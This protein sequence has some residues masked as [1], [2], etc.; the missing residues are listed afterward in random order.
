[1]CNTLDSTQNCG[2]ELNVNTASC[3]QRSKG[4][5]VSTAGQIRRALPKT[6]DSDAIAA[7]WVQNNLRVCVRERKSSSL[8]YVLAWYMTSLLSPPPQDPKSE[9]CSISHEAGRR[10]VYSEIRASRRLTHHHRGWDTSTSI[11]CEKVKSVRAQRAQRAWLFINEC[12][13]V[14][15]CR[16]LYFRQLAVMNVP[17]WHL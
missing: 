3:P 8:A 2:F 17:R 14:R 12:E 5:S 7:W 4:L 1:M 15:E 13:D 11:G 9:S 6:P 16:R 10:A